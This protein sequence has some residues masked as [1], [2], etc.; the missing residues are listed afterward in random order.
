M[1]AGVPQFDLAAFLRLH[2]SRA[3]ALQWLLGAGTSATAGVPTAWHM[4]WE[5]KRTIF[6]SEQR[7]ALSACQNLSEAALRER[8]QRHF[9]AAG[10]HPPLDDPAEY[11]HYFELAYPD[12][13]DRRAYIDAKVRG[14]E[15]SFGHT[16]LAV[17]IAAGRVRIVWT[18]NFDPALETSCVRVLGSTGHLAV[19][20]LDNPTL[21]EEAIAEERWPLAGKLHGD[22]QSMRLKN[23]R[24]ELREQ[25]ARLR[26]ALVRASGRYGLIVCGYSGRDASVMDALD[27]AAVE[28]GFP[29]G[30]FWIHCG[31]T[32]PLPRVEQLIAKATAVG[33]TGA[34]VEAQNF[35]EL[36]GDVLRQTPD[37]PAEVLD[38]AEREAPRVSHAP[39]P[40]AGTQWP[41]IRTNAL[42]VL[43]WPSSARRIECDIGGAKA[44]RE[45]LRDAGIA[46]RVVAARTKPGVLAFGADDALRKALE[47]H[48]ITQSDLHTIET[49]RLRYESGEHGLLAEAVAIALARD[50]PLLVRRRR[51]GWALVVDPRKW[52]EPQL[53]SLTAVTGR[54]LGRLPSGAHWAEAVALRLDWHLD[55][56]WLL[57]DPIIWM[58][59]SNGRRPTAD[60]DF[61]RERRARR[62]NPQS[63]ALLAAWIGILLGRQETARIS[64]FG[65]VDGI[66][67]TFVIAGTTAYSRRSTALAHRHDESEAA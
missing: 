54:P 42:P 35:D 50:R 31:E 49:H 62:Y 34:I 32:P 61:V 30:L 57:L 23:I 43:D 33:I 41:A 3:P 13:K 47:P 67:A 37:L 38:R 10:G 26:G 63:D 66:D 46:D 55:R 60:M 4:I 56:L 1:T 24:E 18:T 7:V 28:G 64:A 36:M 12:E 6:C 48:T 51:L 9:D 16:C 20:T 15:P 59:R 27:E 17:L 53:A 14:V 19:A 25:D 11:A 39:L 21:A 8:I 29:A 2:G 45:A 65:G 5:F 52:N 22:F 40:A 58:S 44:L